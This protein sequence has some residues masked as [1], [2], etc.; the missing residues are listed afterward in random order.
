MYGDKN[1]D[2]LISVTK[3]ILFPIV[4]VLVLMAA[5]A[6]G[7]IEQKPAAAGP[8]PNV[9]PAAVNVKSAEKAPAVSPSEP[10]VPK[11]ASVPVK[12]QSLSFKKDWPI[13]DALQFLGA[14]YQKNIVPS[15]KVDGLITITNLYDVT[16]EEALEAILGPVLKY[17]QEGNFIKVYTADEYKQIKEDVGR[18]IYKVF[19]LYYISA[20][21]AVKL[22][23]PVLSK[24]GT[25]QASSP[26]E[27]VVPTGESI[28]VGSGGGDTMALNDTL[29]ILDYPENIAKAEK[30]IKELDVRPDQV[31]IEAT[32][33]SATLTEETALGID[34]NTLNGV[35]IDSILSVGSGTA[36]GISTSKFAEGLKT[37]S[38]T[39]G[40]SV[41]ITSDHVAAL[42]KAI[43]SV[44]DVTILAN[45]KILA[46]NKQLGQVYIG[47]KVAYV[48]QSTTTE[49]GNVTQQ[50][51]FLE[52]GTKLSFRPYI[53]DDGYIRMDIHPKDSSAEL[54]LVGST[55]LPDET[56]AE[57]AT[58]IFVK[59]GQTIVIGG[60]FRD[61][62]NVTRNQ[63]PLLG[64]LPLIGVAFR[65][66]ADQVLREEVVVMLTPHIVKEPNETGGDARI[67]DIRRKR[68]GAMD[69]LN[70]IG[71]TKQ[72]EDSYARAVNYYLDGNSE[73]AMKQLAIAFNLRPTYLE[74][75]RLKER[76]ITEAKPEDVSK[77][78]RIMLE[79]IDK[80]EAGK[81]MR[82]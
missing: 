52:T 66:T 11:D 63:V 35:T 75:I 81:W 16:F 36:D 69:E 1:S 55:S 61:K 76:I 6:V 20:G 42:I 58:N 82:R 49:G 51:D 71:R 29:V 33:L 41:G 12:I 8:D 79:A 57:L 67:D 22:I 43:E 2:S 31:L 13:R 24:A 72:A 25:I 18:M 17:E 15:A 37:T 28:S 4:C 53:G 60:M 46:V 77:L 45:P 23:A 50:V 70:V 19:T 30:L 59:N 26:A 34:W 9:V 56:S 44:T 74:A 64:D 21:E 39:G 14:R 47:K 68:F 80:Q 65:S 54:R 10:I 62:Y 38:F 48:S 3:K 78:E 40:L 32:I 73:S 27:K 5:M 7:G